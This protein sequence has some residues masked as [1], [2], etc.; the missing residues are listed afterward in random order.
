[1]V[2]L[3]LLDLFLVDTQ[4][5]DFHQHQVRLVGKDQLYGRDNQQLLKVSIDNQTIDY[6]TLS[7]KPGGGI[8][9][10]PVSIPKYN[11]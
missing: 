10:P 3:S 7:N 8:I 5:E 11:L 9:A 1:M 6:V 4:M 2:T